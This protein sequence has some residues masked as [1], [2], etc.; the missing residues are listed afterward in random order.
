MNDIVLL[1]A[2]GVHYEHPAHAL[3]YTFGGIVY[4]G[5]RPRLPGVHPKIH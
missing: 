4:R 1:S 5:A 3:S 2:V